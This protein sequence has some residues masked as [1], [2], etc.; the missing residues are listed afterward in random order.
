MNVNDVVIPT[1][2][3]TPLEQAFN[4]LERQGNLESN[5][6]SIEGRYSPIIN[7]NDRR[8]QVIIKDFLWRIVEEIGEALESVKN[9]ESVTKTC[10]ELADG[11]H[12]IAGL[13]VIT[14]HQHEFSEAWEY[15]AEDTEEVASPL[16]LEHLIE[17]I[18]TLGNTLKMK[19]WKQTDV[20]TDTNLFKKK[21]IEVVKNYLYF[22]RDY[23][24]LRTQ[25]LWEYYYKKSEVNLFR[26]RSKY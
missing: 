16:N 10:E 13:C 23:V 18:G 14:G 9:K 11:L 5:Y 21:L 8:G 24:D 7:I 15:V 6:W 22:C 1:H 26:I 3:K 19:P 25:E 4:I 2:I 20:L 12:F 17:S